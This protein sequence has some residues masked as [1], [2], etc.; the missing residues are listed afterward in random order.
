MLQAINIAN[1]KTLKLSRKTW[2]SSAIELNERDITLGFQRFLF[3]LLEP[4]SYIR[5]CLSGSTSQKDLN[6]GN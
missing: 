5:E 2:Q 4:V 3:W 1:T 6:T